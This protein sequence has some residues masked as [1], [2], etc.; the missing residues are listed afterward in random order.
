MA[1]LGHNSAFDVAVIKAQFPALQQKI[2]GDKPLVYL[3]SAASAQVPDVVINRMSDFLR[4]DYSN[5]HRGVHCL[6]QR[7]TDAFEGARAAVASFIGASVDEVVFTKGTTEAINL[8]ASSY[9]QLIEPG[10][11]VIVTELEH[12]SNIIPWQLLAQR[13]GLTL[14]VVPVLEDGQLDMQQFELLLSP[15]T[16]LVAC[17]HVSNVL[18]TV[19]P[20]EQII[21]KAHAVGAKVLLDASQAVT[22]RVVDVKALDVDFLAFTGHKVYGPNGIGVLYAKAELLEAMPPYQGGGEMIDRV[23]WQGSTYK[24]GPAKFEAGTPPITEAIGLHSAI[25]WMQG[26]GVEAI[27]A[28]EDKVL[29]YAT[30]RLG[31]IPGLRIHGTAPQKVSVI[32]FSFDGVHAMDVATI[33]DKTGVAV[34]VGQHCAEPL[35][36][37]L[38]V[39]STARASFAAYNDFGD[40]DALVEG[41]KL[42]QEL[43]A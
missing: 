11:E 40:V 6:S 32:T 10:S 20:V 2:Y 3:D 39:S 23:S 37:A 34:R 41:I 8:V 24:A 38:G 31:E 35:H 26:V 28:H 15:K 5:V 4:Q 29:T 16:A 17:A 25:E 33:L 27:A 43:L 9:G 12:H 22:H 21:Q 36:D 1:E 13:Q 19:L 7:A 14:K 42:A 30:Q 18:G